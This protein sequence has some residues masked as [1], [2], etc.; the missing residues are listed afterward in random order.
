[1]TNLIRLLG[2][3]LRA[4][5][6]WMAILSALLIVVATLALVYEVIT[7]YYLR[8]A[9]DWMI[10]FCVYLL[11]AATFL[12]A[13]YT[14]A[15]RGHVGI[16]VLDEVM[17]PKWNRYRL[18]AGDVLSLVVVFFI[19]RNAWHFSWNAYE[20]GWSTSST[21]A[22]PLWIPYFFMAFGLSTMALQMVAQI[23]ETLA[24]RVP[25]KK[26]QEQNL[27]GA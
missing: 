4:F 26:H 20:Q 19:A 16:E 12:A 5:N 23:I 14:Q 10:E 9:N 15:E 18:L 21:W 24:V 8:V 25:H 7:R 17:S 13:A 3:S 22:P 6:R 27:M 1:M 2:N 11:I